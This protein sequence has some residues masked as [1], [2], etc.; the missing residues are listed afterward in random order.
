MFPRCLPLGDAAILVQLGEG[1]D[2]ALNARV[3]ALA[4]LV[5][6]GAPTGIGEAVGAYC[7]LTV[8]YDPMRIAYSEALDWVQRQAQRVGELDLPVPRTV[9][10]P[11][12][13][14]GEQ[15]PDLDFIARHT[16]LTPG[17]VI[18]LH[19]AGEYRV[20]LLG[21][22]PGFPYLG[23]L[24]PRL[25]CPRLATPRPAVPAGSVGIAGEQTGIYPVT[26]PGGWRIIGCTP[27]ILF[28]VQREPPCLLAPG[29]VVRFVPT[30][31][32]GGER[33]F[34]GSEERKG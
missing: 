7:T 15:G 28:D 31:R 27:A 30:H 1:I 14:G 11:V 17:E 26:S 5:E 10:I 16:G 33:I 4:Q 8:H 9:E 21:F 34:P 18:R 13:Y 20:Y 25:A 29:D 22:T 19:A 2:P 6:A 24:H 12:L 23:G 32:A 3:Q